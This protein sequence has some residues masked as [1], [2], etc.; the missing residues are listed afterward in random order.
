MQFEHAHRV[1]LI[2]ALL[3]IAGS[4]ALATG[5][6]VAALTMTRTP[7]NHSGI[8]LPFGGGVYVGGNTCFTCHGDE[9]PDWLLTLEPQPAAAPMANPHVVAADASAHVVIP[10]VEFADTN[11][12][13]ENN[14]SRQQYIIETEDDHGALPEGMNREALK[15]SLTVRLRRASSAITAV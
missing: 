5:L 11:I 3:A 13:P 10:H 14:S 8:N 9:D 4:A 2:T 15:P 1:R 12:L 6:F 7:A